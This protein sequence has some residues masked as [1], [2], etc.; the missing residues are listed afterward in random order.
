MPAPEAVRWY[1]EGVAAL[2]DGTYYKASQALARAVGRDPQFSMAHARLAE[3]YLELEYLEKAKDEMLRAVP[4]GSKPRLT[5]AEQ[6]YEQAPEL[7]AIGIR[8]RICRRAIDS[9]PIS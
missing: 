3:A 9:L 8:W 7:R 5:R 4:P 1:Q 2:R 6:L